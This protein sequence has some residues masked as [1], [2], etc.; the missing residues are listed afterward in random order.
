MTDDDI[1][2]LFHA[3]RGVICAVGAGG[4]KSTLYNL[5]ARHPGRVALT[6]TVFTARFPAHLGLT[7]AIAEESDLPARAEA[8]SQMDRIGFA[9]PSGKPGRYAG[10]ATEMVSRLHA[11]TR[12][13]ATFVKADGARMRW[14]KAPREGEPVLPANCS[15]LICICSAQ[16]LGKPLSYEI[17]HRL[18]R[19]T[20]VTEL[21]EGEVIEPQHL[22]RLMVSDSG[23]LKGSRGRTVVPVINMVDDAEREGLARQVAQMAL[24]NTCR[25]DRVILTS[26]RRTDE[27]VVAV[28]ER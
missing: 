25:F 21:Q 9:A 12:R 15:T 1:L 7:S 5:V 6:G 19:I 20:A 26:M 17:A 22:A 24:T 23:M 18:E 8:I 27:P 14:L 11:E 4:K 16:A 3:R 2:D 10:L 28:V 13:D